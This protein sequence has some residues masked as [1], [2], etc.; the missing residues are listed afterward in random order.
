MGN[1]CHNFG[2]DVLIYLTRALFVY[3]KSPATS[4]SRIQMCDPNRRVEAPIVCRGPRRELRSPP[5]HSPN[6]PCVSRAAITR[7]SQATRGAS[8][9]LSPGVVR[10]A[11]GSHSVNPLPRAP[12]VSVKIQR[13]ATD[14]ERSRGEVGYA[15]LRTVPVSPCGS[16][17]HA[18]NSYQRTVPFGICVQP[19]AGP[20]TNSRKALRVATMAGSGT[21][22]NVVSMYA[23]SSSDTPYKCANAAS[24]SARSSMRS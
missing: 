15:I 17:V 5:R 21:D 7:E 9:I 22:G 2:A 1:P 18:R 12:A 23:K 6:S 19:A 13:A 4:D 3:E 8:R 24:S 16:A 10:R 14:R 11:H 20:Y